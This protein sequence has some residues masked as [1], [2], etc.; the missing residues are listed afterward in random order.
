MQVIN[1]L[2]ERSFEYTAEKENLAVRKDEIGDLM[3]IIAYCQ[4]D[5][6]KEP[7]E[8]QEAL[9]ETCVEEGI[10][11]ADW[12]YGKRGEGSEDDRRRM[13]EALSKKALIESDKDR[14]V[15]EIANLKNI[16][17]ALGGF[18]AS[19][20]T[21]E[22]YVQERRE[23]LSSIKNVTDYEAFMQSCFINSRFAKGILPEMKHISNFS[24]NTKEITKALGILN[25]HAVTLYQQY[26]TQ[27]EE[28]MRILSAKL[29]RECAPDPKHSEELI[30][31]FTY[32]ENIEGA[33]VAK[34]K[35]VECSPHLKLLHPG[36]NLR[37]Y[38]YWCDDTI[39]NGKKVLVGRIGRH[40]Y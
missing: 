16:N 26:S 22:K 2:I 34:T 30:F 39:G 9:W 7:L 37:I 5:V 18:Q 21:V 38:F 35:D 32:S 33:K 24:D 8:Y 12:L 23:I 13:L 29:Q 36:S 20:S 31:T 19:V 40:P 28:A 6:V 4:D 1:S 25:D 27:L 15:H 11:F 14:P 17:I 3:E 10:T